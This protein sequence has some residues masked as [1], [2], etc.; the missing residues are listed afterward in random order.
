MDPQERKAAG[1]KLH[2]DIFGIRMWALPDGRYVAQRMQQTSQNARMSIHSSER[3]LQLMQDTA[4]DDVTSLA[5][6]LTDDPIIGY[7]ATEWAVHHVKDEAGITVNV[8]LLSTATCWYWE[9]IELEKA[10]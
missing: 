7:Q 3:I 2:S 4:L 10:A 5:V 6:S 9:R 1:W 8:E